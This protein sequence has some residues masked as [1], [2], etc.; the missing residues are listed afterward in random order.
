[1]TWLRGLQCTSKFATGPPYTEGARGK[2]DNGTG[3]DGTC[4]ATPE[5][6]F[7]WRRGE[8]AGGCAEKT[9]TSSHRRRTAGGDGHPDGQRSNASSVFRSGTIRAAH[10]RQIEVPTWTSSPSCG[11]NS[12]SVPRPQQRDL[13]TAIP[14][15]HHGEFSRHWHAP[16]VSVHTR[17]SCWSEQCRPQRFFWSTVL[18]V[19]GLPLVI[20]CVLIRGAPGVRMRLSVRVEL[21]TRQVILTN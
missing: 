14:D 17:S 4:V 7:K 12:V 15:P 9:G 13:L 11:V 3:A 6:S 18:P 2:E 8:G 16:S 21:A 19:L 10:V 5:A 1:M 20:P